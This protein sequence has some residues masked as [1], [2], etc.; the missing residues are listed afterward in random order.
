MN[1][2]KRQGA[3]TILTKLRSLILPKKGTAPPI[4][5]PIQ[6]LQLSPEQQK[7]LNAEL[8]SAAANGDTQKAKELLDKGADVNAKSDDGLAA[9]VYA[10][11]YGHTD[12][13]DMLISEGAYVN[14]KGNGGFTALMAAAWNGHRETADMLIR[15]KANVDARD[16]F[17]IS[18]QMF[19]AARGHAETADM[20]RRQK[21]P[22]YAGAGCASSLK[23]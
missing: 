10:A 18:A 21:W 22:Y 19:A 23:S 12:T 13:A 17:G 20:L 4:A 6:R 5:E 15:N 9:L 1:E 16:T 7:R 2:T 14:S 8:L 3:K 11:W